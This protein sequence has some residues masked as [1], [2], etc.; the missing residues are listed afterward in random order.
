MSKNSSFPE[1]DFILNWVLIQLIL[2]KYFL[3]IFPYFLFEFILNYL[4]FR[5][6]INARI[7]PLEMN[8]IKK[9]KKKEMN[10]VWLSQGW[11]APWFNLAIQSLDFWLLIQLKEECTHQLITWSDHLNWK[12]YILKNGY[13]DL[14]FTGWSL[15]AW[16]WIPCRHYILV[17]LLS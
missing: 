14:S 4:F 1:Q 2:K 12:G 7:H 16:A 5:S 10:P 17:T 15:R 9:K 6:K 11:W 3:K 13:T 8:P